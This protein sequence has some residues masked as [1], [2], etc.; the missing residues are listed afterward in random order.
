MLCVGTH[1]LMVV[2][3]FAVCKG[4]SIAVAG[5]VTRGKQAQ[6][7]MKMLKTG[8]IAYPGVIIGIPR[9]DNDV[10]LIHFI[11]NLKLR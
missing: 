1:N 5:L 4:P 11:T 10:I 6:Q 9:K 7:S 8:T 3:Q 2:V